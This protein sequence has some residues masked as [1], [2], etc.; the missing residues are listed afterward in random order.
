MLTLYAVSLLVFRLLFL[1]SVH[2]YSPKMMQASARGKASGDL[3]KKLQHK[4]AP[5]IVP[6]TSLRVISPTTALTP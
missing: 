3:M 4:I 5:K 1:F 2:T 6:S